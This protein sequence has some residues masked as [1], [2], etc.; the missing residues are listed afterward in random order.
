M[1]A[2]TVGTVC[3][4]H[5]WPDDALSARTGHVH[6]RPP[7]GHAVRPNI[8]LICVDQL[9]PFEVGCYGHPT[10]KTPGIDRLAA[11]GVRF[12][13]CVSNNPVCT[14]A[15]S[16]LVSGQY[17]RT[18]AGMMGNWGVPDATRNRFPDPTLPEVFAA[19]GYTP[20]HLGKW[21]VHV[22][23]RLL[24]FAN[25]PEPGAEPDGHRGYFPHRSDKGERSP[26]WPADERQLIDGFLDEPPRDRPWFCFHNIH[27]PHG[28]WFGIEER[29]QRMYGRGDV[30]LRPNVPD[31]PTDAHDRKWFEIYWGA[32]KRGRE[33]PLPKDPYDI[34]DCH[35]S[36]FGMVSRADA[37]VR[38]I[39]RR[40]DETGLADNTIVVFT[41]DHGENLRSHGLY[42]KETMNEESIRVPLVVRGPGVP[43]G[44]VNRE[45]IM[46]LVDLPATLLSL[47]GIDVPAHL[48]G[49][50][51]AAVVRGEAAT[52]GD[53]V[54]FIE[55]M[56]DDIAIR[57]PTHKAV[58]KMQ[59]NWQNT[60]PRTIKDE[61]HGFYDL[62]ADPYEMTNLAKADEQTH[63]AAALRE[64][65]LAWNARTPWLAQRLGRGPGSRPAGMR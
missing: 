52:V 2:A 5:A 32:A 57:T 20:V 23:P 44:V 48:Q 17:S 43:R 46:S 49:V 11:Q 12:E 61:R 39:L 8:L 64:Q 60:P 21:H 24:G 41:S 50:D 53:N 38:H 42:N 14:P 35:A 31:R 22:H 27:L 1:L 25:Q 54:A 15:R 10:V 58:V 47:A 30:T 45:Q 34:V 36:Y 3:C 18:C 16:I 59:G 51:R 40:L 55:G 26:F 33:I 9:R 28:P 13:T 65:L 7:N 19:A 6:S 63:T 4:M 56:Q 29:W 37:E 62:S